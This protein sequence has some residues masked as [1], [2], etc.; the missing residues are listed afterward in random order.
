MPPAKACDTDII[1]IEFTKKFQQDYKK[2]KP[3]IRK[4]VD[5]AIEDL[6]KIPRPSTL[7][8]KKYNGYKNP[9]IYAI[10]V[11]SNHS[12]K[13]S[14]EIQGDKAKLRRIGTHKIVDNSP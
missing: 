6:L 14:L 11:T 10:H 13:I 2:L 12:H 9:H 1:S 3:D 8:L 5:A 7:R 4:H